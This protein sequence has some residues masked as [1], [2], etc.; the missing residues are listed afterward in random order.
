MNYAIEHGA[1]GLMYFHIQANTNEIL[2]DLGAEIGML[3]RPDLKDYYRD[4]ARRRFGAES[5]EALAESLD[6]F[7]DSV[8]FGQ[9]RENSPHKMFLALAPP[10]FFNSAEDMLIKC[11]EET[12]EGR[13]QWIRERL[14]VLRK[15]LPLFGR[16][17]MLA[18][19]VAPRLQHEDFFKQYLWEID[20][21]ASRFEGIE[22]MYL[23]HLHADTDP[24]ES[25]SRYDRAINAFLTFKE[26]FRNRPG[27]R[28]N[29]LRQ[30]EP[31][32]PYT[33]SFLK[34]WETRGYWE[35]SPQTATFMHV[36]WERFDQYEAVIRRM[37]PKELSK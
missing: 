5:A 33:A 4:Y 21:V 9:N 26:L 23:A 36:I 14:D 25:Q 8:D 28:M 24:K 7:C 32:V 22:S 18:R 6:A 15:K 2:A 20:Y 1:N 16:A 30:L 34:D 31:K 27:I 11:N 12:P 37:R 29:E 10:G 35:G 3:G 19:S 17:A 13:K